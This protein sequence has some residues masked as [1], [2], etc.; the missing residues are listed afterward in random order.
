MLKII[1]PAAW[2]FALLT[3]ALGISA[4]AGNASPNAYL[5]PCL[6]IML[7]LIVWRIALIRKEG[8]RASEGTP[9]RD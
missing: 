5:L 9:G 6:T 7:A 2:L 4:L 3:V 1:T 8:Q